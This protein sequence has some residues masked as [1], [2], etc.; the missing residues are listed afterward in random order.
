MKPAAECQ[1]L[2]VRGS[3]PLL[4][5]LR[6]VPERTIVTKKSKE[7]IPSIPISGNDEAVL[8][9]APK[10]PCDFPHVKTG[11]QEFNNELTR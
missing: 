4:A 6:F 2:P 9:V 10:M 8:L 1:T 11:L 3:L 5:I 7:G